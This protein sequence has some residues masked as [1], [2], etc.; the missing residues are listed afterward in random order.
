MRDRKSRIDEQK[1][2]TIKDDKQS[3]SCL[4]AD[5][6]ATGISVITDHFFPTYRE[7]EVVMEIGGKPVS[8]KGSTR[9]SIDP[10]TTID[11]MGKLGIFIMNPPP[12]FLDYVDA[13]EKK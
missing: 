6:S 9:W 10:G 7:I 5:M 12:A 2:V 4:L 8:M 11:R 3:Y 13:R 1:Q